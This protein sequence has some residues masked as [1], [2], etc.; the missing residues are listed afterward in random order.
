MNF[1]NQFYNASF[2]NWKNSMFQPMQLNIP[3]SF[4]SLPTDLILLDFTSHRDGERALNALNVARTSPVVNLLNG[5]L[6]HVTYHNLYNFWRKTNKDANLT[7]RITPCENIVLDKDHPLHPANPRN[8]LKP[9]NPPKI[10]PKPKIFFNFVGKDYVLETVLNVY[11][12]I[13][14]LFN[15]DTDKMVFLENKENNSL[16]FQNSWIDKSLF[17]VEYGFG[18]YFTDN[19]LAAVS[20]IQKY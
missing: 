1:N 19:F 16:V 11:K 6:V 2:L 8:P 4:S 17:K 5:V 18:Q 15:K 10:S 20:L 13:Q 14:P 12:M 3:T 9:A 7:A